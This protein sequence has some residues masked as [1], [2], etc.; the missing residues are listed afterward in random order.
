MIRPAVET[1]QG[2]SPTAV[3]NLYFQLTTKLSAHSTRRNTGIE[4]DYTDLA[5]LI[6]TYADQVGTFLGYLDVNHCQWFIYDAI[7]NESQEASDWYSYVL[8]GPP[9]EEEG[10][11]GVCNSLARGGRAAWNSCERF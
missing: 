4:H 2:K 9:V 6:R 5:Y 11:G 7:T 1:L 8:L 3:I 10:E